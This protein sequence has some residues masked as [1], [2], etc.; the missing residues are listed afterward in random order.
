MSYVA[1]GAP[2]LTSIDPE[3][4]NP[5]DRLRSPSL[6]HWFGTDHLGRDIFARALYGSRVSLIG[7]L[8][9]STMS[10]LVGIAIGLLSGYHRR[11]D[12]VAMHVMDGL[13]AIP[14]ILL[15]AIALMALIHALKRPRPC[16]IGGVFL[17]RERATTRMYVPSHGRRRLTS[18]RSPW[19]RAAT[20]LPVAHLLP[21]AA[22]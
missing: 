15:L 20:N 1:L 14:G 7:G 5:V 6:E 3:E 2:L 9:V 17:C 10:T 19:L 4:I 16:E 8:R 12:V 21:P 11:L 22:G 18:H 13:M